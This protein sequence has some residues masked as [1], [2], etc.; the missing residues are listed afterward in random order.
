MGDSQRAPGQRTILF[1]GGGTGGHI[2]PNIGIAQQLAAQRDVAIH[3][4]VSNRP[5]DAAILDR[6]PHP[7]TAS[8]AVPLPSARRPWKAVNF[9]AAFRRAN[10]QIN[11][12]IEEHDV[13]LVV[14][15]GGFVSGPAIVTAARHRLPRVLCNLDAVPGQANRRLSRLCTKVFSTYETPQLRDAERVGLPLRDVSRHDGDRASAREKVGLDPNLDTLFIT[16]ATHGAESIILA[17]M[18]LI[19]TPKHATHFE[20]WQVLHQCG[21]FDVDRL[22]ASYDEA[23]VRAKVVAYCD[24]MGAAWCASNIAIS[25]AGA[26]SVAEAWAN[27]IPTIF[28]PNPYHADQHQRHNAAPLADAGG[29]SLITDHID[30]PKTVQSLAPA[31]VE[32]MSDVDRRDTMSAALTKSCPPDGARRIAEY[33]GTHLGGE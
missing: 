27:A 23:N 14:A 30:A 26:G 1:A 16:G 24:E 11:R 13:A 4:L 3:F 31:L 7:Y 25:R 18:E 21:T 20:G 28:L 12:L 15:T 32:L 29:A 9:V 22:Q 5:G 2:Y 33:I 19:A 6:F 8:P 10:K 17:M